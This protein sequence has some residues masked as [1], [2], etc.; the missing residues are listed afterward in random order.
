MRTALRN[1]SSCIV[2]RCA[3]GGC[4]LVL[5]PAYELGSA[6]R[7][8]SEYLIV[9][10]SRTDSTSLR[11]VE[12]WSLFGYLAQSMLWLSAL[13]VDLRKVMLYE[14][15]DVLKNK[16][17]SCKGI[18]SGD[19]WIFV[20]TAFMNGDLQKKSLSVK[21]EGFWKTGKS[22]SVYRADGK[23]CMGLCKHK[24]VWYEHSQSS[25][26]Q[27]FLQRFSAEDP[28]LFTANRQTHSIVITIRR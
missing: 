16:L 21:P 26:G 12:G 14:Y 28:T 8:Q 1:S 3:A 25:D 9:S 20:K 4:D 10:P 11:D 17:G 22:Y 6:P 5:C 7:I 2:R 24:G 15:G 13:K 27:H 19:V 23:L 18:S